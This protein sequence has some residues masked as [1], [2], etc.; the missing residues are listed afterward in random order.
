MRSGLVDR[1]RFR[2]AGE[3]AAVRETLLSLRVLG[4]R[5]PAVGR[6][7]RRSK[8]EGKELQSTIGLRVA[9]R[10]ERMP[11]Q[12]G[13]GQSEFADVGEVAS[14]WMTK[15][16]LSSGEALPDQ[17]TCPSRIRVGD[18]HSLVL[19]LVLAGRTAGLGGVT[20]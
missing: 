15:L 16:R 11:A 19:G 17:D 7:R 3:V 10:H 12:D 8:E 6:Q 9:G 4:K 13:R 14:G 1:R 20:T 2:M 5:K 18:G